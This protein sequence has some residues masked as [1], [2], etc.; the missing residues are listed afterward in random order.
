MGSGLNQSAVYHAAGAGCGR[1]GCTLFE[2]CARSACALSVRRSGAGDSPET[3]ILRQVPDVTGIITNWQASCFG[4]HMACTDAV[5]VRQERRWIA[6]IKA[7]G[8]LR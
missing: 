8:V 4:A 5:P 1:Q 7:V 6:S 2:Q 3:P